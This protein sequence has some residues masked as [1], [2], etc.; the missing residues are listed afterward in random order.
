MGFTE[1]IADF[2]FRHEA[3]LAKGYLDDAGIESFLVADDAGGNL[4][5][6]LEND[7]AILVRSVDAARARQVLH[8]AGMLGEDED[9]A[10]AND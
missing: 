4:G 5:L 7:A 6:T 8:D 1:K 10:P 3:E 2:T 9:E